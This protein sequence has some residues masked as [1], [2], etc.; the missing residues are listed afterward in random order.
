MSGTVCLAV[1]RPQPELL[2]IQIESI[3]SQTLEDWRCLVGIDGIDP[4]ARSA[5]E[6]AIGQD[7]RFEIIEFETNVGFYRN[8][9]RL[10]A[11]V[12]GTSDWVALADQDDAWFAEK[13]ESLVPLLRE[14]DLAFGQAV[15]VAGGN[16]PSRHNVTDRRATT[17]AAAFIDNQ[18]TGSM[19][20]F[21]RSLLD[22]AL[23]M[24]DPTD[25]AFHDHWLGI[26]ALAGGGIAALPR[27][28]QNYVQHGGNVIGEES[29][30][31]LAQ[32]LSSLS[33]RSGGGVTNG[34]DYIS[35]HRWR[36][37]V[38]MAAALERSDPVEAGDGFVRAVAADR[39]SLSLITGVVREIVAGRVPPLRAL[40]LLAGA[41]R[42][43]RHRRAR[44]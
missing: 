27:P 14:A 35:A 2:R 34:L 20:V 5:V 22:R 10:L 26:C 12:P 17:L 23:P 30:R 25:S 4:S 6:D 29:P 32:R 44:P 9:E 36:W 40:A 3:R 31:S 1:F 8:F 38:N 7:D 11:A 18:V 19:S 39:L 33:G 16:A 37:R 42:S 41:W 15:V 28:V 43:P 21:R 24:P 13:L